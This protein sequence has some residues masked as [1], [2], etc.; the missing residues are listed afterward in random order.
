MG[1]GFRLAFGP[2]SD[3]RIEE[4]LCRRIARVSDRAQFI[5]ATNP[6]DSL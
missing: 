4:A 1:Y 6:L 3:G 5:T 2:L